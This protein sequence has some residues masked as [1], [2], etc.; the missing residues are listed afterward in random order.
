MTANPHRHYPLPNAPGLGPDAKA[1][2]T[3]TARATVRPIDNPFRAQRTDALAFVEFDLTVLGVAQDLAKHNHR[4]ALVGPHGTGKSTLLQALGDHLVPHGL[5]PLPLFMNSDERGTFP[6]VWRRTIANAHPNDLLLL[7]GYDLLPIWARAWVLHKS[8]PAG[9]LIVTSHRHTRLPT[10]AI[11]RTSPA[12]L[13]QLLD[14]LDPV[15]AEQI[16][17]F[18]LYRRCDGNLRDAL[19]LAYDQATQD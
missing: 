3:S 6:T 12:L 1:G 14:E 10:V 7:D 15:A 11:T 13:E 8:R 9:G 4:G 17:A 19:R 2:P 5:C 18:S 16:D